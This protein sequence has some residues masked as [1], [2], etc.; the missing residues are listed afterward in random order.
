MFRVQFG[1]CKVRR[2]EETSRTIF[3][4]ASKQREYKAKVVDAQMSSRYSRDHVE[5]ELQR[6]DHVEKEKEEASKWNCPSLYMMLRKW[7]L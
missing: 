5:V 3:I 7:A 6:F 4:T 1:C 2:I